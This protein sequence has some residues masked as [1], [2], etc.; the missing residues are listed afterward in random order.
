MK[1]PTSIMIYSFMIMI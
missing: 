1:I